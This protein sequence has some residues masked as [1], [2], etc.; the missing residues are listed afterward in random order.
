MVWAAYSEHYK[1]RPEIKLDY[2]GTATIAIALTLLLLAV[3]KGGEFGA[4]FTIISLIICALLTIV[5][6]RRLLT[7]LIEVGVAA[8]R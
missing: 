5:F 2:A 8:C 3:E 4:T 1:R 6:I 7:Q